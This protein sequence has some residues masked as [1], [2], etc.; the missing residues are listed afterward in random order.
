MRGG[1]RSSPAA[2]MNGAVAHPGVHPMTARPA[3]AQ[4]LCAVVRHD[5]RLPA[6][7]GAT[8]R[9]SA[10]RVRSLAAT[11]NKGLLGT[12]VRNIEPPAQPKQ[13]LLT[14]PVIGCLAHLD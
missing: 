7:A 11:E 2:A 6:F 12:G 9:A 5:Q 3:S 13:E 10:S 14:K 4:R 1:T 8:G